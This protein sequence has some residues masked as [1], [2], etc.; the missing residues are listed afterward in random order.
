M[1]LVCRLLPAFAALDCLVL[2]FWAIVQPNGLFALLGCAPP[3]DA[4]LWS[5]FGYLSL[6]NAGCLAAAAIRPLEFSGFALVP[7][8]GRLLSCALWMWLL[9]Q[10]RVALA[11]EPLWGLLAHDAFWLV[12]LTVFLVPQFIARRR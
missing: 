10:S 7:W 1:A 3:R 5:V 8:V 2:G 9:G 12:A 6:A 11:P 4:F